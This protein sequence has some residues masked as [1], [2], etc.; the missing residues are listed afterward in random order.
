MSGFTI[1]GWHV[2]L[3]VTA[4]FALII[5]VDGAFM[6]LAYQSHPGQVAS[7]PYEAGLLFN[8]ELERQHRQ[9]MLGWR[10]AAEARRDGVEVWLRDREGLPLIGL[11][12]TADLQRPATEHGRTMLTLVEAEPGHYVGQRRNL[13]GT[14][15]ATIS[16]RDAN[17]RDFVASRR[18]SW[19]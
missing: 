3:A 7:K 18:L 9:R 13:T 1:K 14:W 4:F 6:A 8:A 10:A 12:V 19:P 11:I 16:A 2:G 17:G 15:D 5:A